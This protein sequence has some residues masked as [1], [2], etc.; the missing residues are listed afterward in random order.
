MKT[1]R[2]MRCYRCGFVTNRGQD[3]VNNRCRCGEMLREM[4]RRRFGQRTFKATPTPET[5]P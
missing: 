1:K 5:T 3:V 4:P 2:N